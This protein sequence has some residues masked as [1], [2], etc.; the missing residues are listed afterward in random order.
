IA[1]AKIL[2]HTAFTKLER[3]GLLIGRLRNNSILITDVA[4]TR[5]RG[6]ATH[7]KLEDIDQASI[8][9]FLQKQPTDEIICGWYHSHPKMGADFFSSIDKGTQQRYQDLFPNAIG[10]VVD[11]A[12]FALTGKLKDAD[13]RIYRI[14]KAKLQEPPFKM[15]SSSEE[16]I[17]NTVTVIHREKTELTDLL[18]KITE[19]LRELYSRTGFLPKDYVTK[20]DLRKLSSDLVVTMLGWTFIVIILVI[21]VAIL[22]SF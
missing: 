12:K 22:M 21:M 2:E 8:A 5:Q 17:E 18:D 9:E 7:V 14:E 1:L 3:A 4:I 10:L 13:I 11:A 15:V 6:T 16:I 19:R 20:K